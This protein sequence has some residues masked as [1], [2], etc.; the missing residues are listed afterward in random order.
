MT[1]VR[2]PFQGNLWQCEEP[3]HRIAAYAGYSFGMRA[4]AR[5]AGIAPL[6]QGIVTGPRWARRLARDFD[7][8]PD[9]GCALDGEEAPHY[10][11]SVV[12][13]NG[14]FPAFMRGEQLT[15]TEQIDGLHE[16]LSALGVCV[17]FLILPDVVGDA[18]A[19]KARTMAAIEAFKDLDPSRFLIAAQEGVELDWLTGVVRELGCGVFVGGRGWDFKAAMLR[20][21]RPLA[22]PWV[23]V[24]RVR[25]EAQFAACAMAGAHAVDSTSWLRA[26][27]HNRAK[28]RELTDALL[29]WA[30]P[31][32]TPTI[33]VYPK[34]P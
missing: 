18:F 25:S 2:N 3:G 7:I 32:A 8:D 10:G 29:K 1:C 6:L 31:R 24:G 12:L 20:T 34:R 33:D 19:S 28:L 22:L 30:H 16:G 23:H 14:A 27:H 5:E 13:D 4:A 17:E 9:E 21:L 15:L 11:A 26:Q